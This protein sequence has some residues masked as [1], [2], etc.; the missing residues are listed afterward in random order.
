MDHV[1]V[2]ERELFSIV[3]FK[4]M[5]WLKVF[6]ILLVEATEKGTHQL[7]SILLQ[8]LRDDLWMF[9]VMQGVMIC[10]DF[11]RFKLVKVDFLF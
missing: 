9:S 5:D 4:E 1:H 3:P 2:K 10:N 11:E 7:K 6:S 8:T